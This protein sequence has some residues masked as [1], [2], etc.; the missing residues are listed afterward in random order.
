MINVIIWNEYVHEV[1]DEHVAK[2]YP[3][4]IHGCIK[5]FL[6]FIFFVT[7]RNFE[8]VSTGITTWS[9]SREESSFENVSL[10]LNSLRFFFLCYFFEQIPAIPIELYL[11]FCIFFLS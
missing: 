3:E 2:I 10:N 7:L 6:K 8:V 1:E 4:G 5:N 11:F 9:T